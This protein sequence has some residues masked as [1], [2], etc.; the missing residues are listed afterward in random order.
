M[1]HLKFN[2][3]AIFALLLL[4][5]CTKI[6]TTTLGSELIPVVD[7]VNTFDT[8]LSVIANTYVGEE[9]YRLS[10]SS[11]HVVG[12]ITKDPVFGRSKATLFFQMKPS[13]YPFTFA[14]HIDSLTGAGVGFDSAVLIL[15]Y[16]S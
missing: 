11:P 1:N 4:T 8:T 16:I 10:A 14:S 13:A 2:W 7:N 5:A 9:E 6:E 3:Q 15:D 12:G